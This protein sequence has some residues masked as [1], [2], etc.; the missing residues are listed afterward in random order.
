M[1]SQAG[2]AGKSKPSRS[3]GSCRTTADPIYRAASVPRSAKCSGA[4]LRPRSPLCSISSRI[5]N[6]QAQADYAI[7]LLTLRQTQLGNRKDLNQVEVDVRNSVVALQQA[8]ARCEP[9]LRNRTLQQ[10]LFDAEQRR[11]RLGASTPYNVAVQQRDL[12]NAQSAA[13]AALV[14]YSTARVALDQTLG[15]TLEAEPHQLSTEVK[16]GKSRERLAS[17]LR[18]RQQPPPREN[19]EMPIREPGVENPSYG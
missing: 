9:Q 8:R 1:E 5:R 11:F 17:P 13:V 16:S 12:I 7:D 19:S 6:R 3:M 2:L 14:A 18:G 15:I 10:Q 4:I